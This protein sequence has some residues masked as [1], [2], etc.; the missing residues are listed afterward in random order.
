ME[1]VKEQAACRICQSKNLFEYLDFGKLPLANSYLSP[2]QSQ[3][4]EFTAPLAIRLCENCGLSQLSHVVDP[5]LMFTHY[6]YV[7]STPKTFREHCDELAST[8]AQFVREKS[9]HFIL[10]I[11]SN[12]GCLLRP[13]RLLGFKILGVDP[14]KNLAREA[15]AKGIPTICDFWSGAVAEQVVKTHGRPSLITGTNV[16][17]HVD[18]IHGFL[19]GITICL[20]EEGF[21]ILEFPYILDFIE[22]N[23]FDTVY[24]EHLS[25]VGIHPV[26]VLM[27]EHSM[28]IIH[29]QHFP[30]I[31]GGTIRVIA[32]RKEKFPVSEEV[33]VTFQKEKTF[34]ISS[35]EPYLAFAQRVEANKTELV[36]LLTAAKQAGRRLW[37]YGAS[38]KGNTLLNYFGI[39]NEMVERIIDDNPMKWGL[40]TPGT[41]IPIS[42]IDSLKNNSK[43]VNDLLLL[44]WNFADEIRVRCAAVGYPGDFIYPVPKPKR[45]SIKAKNWEEE[46]HV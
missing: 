23:L 26:S 8:A 45:V 5:N 18:D 9:Q 1:H 44:A 24:H 36:K 37:A 6:L 31:H 12:D 28:E 14:A 41:R 22:R 32:A 20:D 15:N 17:A 30:N 7:S 43:Q 46:I 34:G 13:F 29:V 35:R 4:P 10:D 33:T 2:D 11:G 16:F 25:Y 27:K 21:L 42:G 3:K 38:A 39:T 19:E 40:L